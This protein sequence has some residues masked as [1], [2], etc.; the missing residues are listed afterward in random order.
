ML[1]AR[2]MGAKQVSTSRIGRRRGSV[3]VVAFS[4]RR[5]GGLRRRLRRQMGGRG[6][7]QREG[8]R[9]RDPQRGT[10]PGADCRS[11]PTP[12]ASTCCAARIVRSGASSAPRTRNTSTRSPRRSAGWAARPKPKPEELDSPGSTGQ[13]DFLTLAYELENA[14]LAA[15]LEAAPPDDCRRRARSPRRS[16]PAMPST[17]S[18]CARASGPAWPSRPPRPSSPAKCRRPAAP[19]GE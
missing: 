17:W 3:R 13:A 1:R 16:P 7:R 14:A 12:G 5:P 18:S 8:R 6:D 15:Y 19:P 2:M 9:R 11:T 10:G 4:R